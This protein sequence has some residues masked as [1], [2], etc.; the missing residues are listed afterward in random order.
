[1]RSTR[2]VCHVVFS[3]LNQTRPCDI[4][5]GWPMTILPSAVVSSN[6]AHSSQAVRPHR[7]IITIFP[8]ATPL[9]RL[10]THL[11]VDCMTTV[12]GRCI[13]LEAYT[14]EPVAPLDPEDPTRTSIHP[15]RT[16]PRSP[17]ARRN[18]TAPGDRT[19]HELQALI[20]CWN[21]STG[22]E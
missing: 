5:A 15:T 21:S 9:P 2:R 6:R 11:L 3:H 22:L 8:S 1:M 18:L 13:V 19:S 17:K 14:V 10:C 7:L 12:F 16:S 4:N 20:L